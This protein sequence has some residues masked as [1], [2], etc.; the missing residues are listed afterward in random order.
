ME[1]AILFADLKISEPLLRAVGDLG[2]VEPTPIQL[3]AI[4]ALLAG[5]DLIGQAK[6]GTGKTAAFA[7]PLLM[8]VEAELGAPQVLVLAPTRELA[9]QVGG[10][11]QDYAKYLDALHVLTIY[12]GQAYGPQ[13]RGL[14]Q[15][16]QIVVGTPGRLIDHL[17]RGALRLDALHTLVLDEGDE[18][19]RMGFIEDV[20][21]ILAAAPPNCQ[22]ALF[23]ATM[24][25]P[26]REI[27]WR[28]L[29]DPVEIRIASKTA[30]VEAISQ[31]Y[32]LLKEEQKAEALLRL[33]EMEEQPAAR[34]AKAE[35]AAWPVWPRP[36]RWRWRNICARRVFCRRRSTAT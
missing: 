26:I 32:I 28:H 36:R 31:Y 19:L 13:L 15:G 24:P 18:M 2:Y 22:K 6:T 10:A 34:E 35:K 25:A 7:L 8:R 3:E 4:P 17:E 29:H 23:S 14:R 33:L 12:G 5:R 16:A 21:K 11:F 27:A 30:T 9:L 1:S 20:E